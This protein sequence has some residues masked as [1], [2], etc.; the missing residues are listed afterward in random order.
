MGILQV[1]SSKKACATAYPSTVQNDIVWFWPDAD[2]RHKDILASKKPPYIAEL[3]DPSF[4]KQI[5]N[6]EF[7]Y[8]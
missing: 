1:Q 8:G 2:P 4:T 3:D 5:A 7:P 6:R